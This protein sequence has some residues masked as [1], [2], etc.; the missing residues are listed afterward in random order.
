M[1]GYMNDQVCISEDSLYCRQVSLST[2]DWSF[3]TDCVLSSPGHLGSVAAMGHTGLPSVSIPEDSWEVWDG[4]GLAEGAGTS[5]R[6]NFPVFHTWRYGVH[7]MGKAA[8]QTGWLLSKLV[9]NVSLSA[10]LGPR[11]HCSQGM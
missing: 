2:S 7:A 5:L 3:P 1:F 4:G 10:H 8:Q 6:L 11:S 9:I